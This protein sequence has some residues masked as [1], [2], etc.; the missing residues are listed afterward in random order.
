MRSTPLALASLF[1]AGSLCFT[2]GCDP[3]TP[4]GPVPDPDP[5]TEVDTEVDTEGIDD[6]TTCDEAEAAL[7]I[8]LDRIQS[9]TTDDQC[10]QVLTGTSCGCTRDLVARLDAD[11]TRFYELLEFPGDLD[12]GGFVSTCDCPPTD[13]FACV[14]GT[15][16]WNYT[17]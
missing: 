7:D 9:C 17:Q 6:P 8:A 1:F 4:S 13:G 16:S 14:E 11:T 10:G 2:A 12:C 3:T 15:C 5:G